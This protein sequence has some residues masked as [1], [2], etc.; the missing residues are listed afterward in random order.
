MY[1]LS[2]R[3]FKENISVEELIK[4]LKEYPPQAKICICGDSYCYIHSE[5]DCSV[6]NIDNEPLDE[7]YDVDYAPEE[8]EFEYGGYHFVP[9][10]VCSKAEN[11]DFNL[12]SRRLNTDTELGFFA[13]NNV[14]G[15]KQKYPY[16]YEA[17]YAAATV[18]T[19]DLFRCRENGRIYIPGENELFEY[20]GDS[21]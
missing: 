10:G 2:K 17:F 5:Q 7:C 12:L 15:R 9:A 4:K 16:T 8:N 1:D 14:I 18:K 19:D 21:K 3:Y 13:Q 11:D 20:I 6:V